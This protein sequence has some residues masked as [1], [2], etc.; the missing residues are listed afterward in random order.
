M[1]KAL[2]DY[3]RGNTLMHAAFLV[4]Y[5][6]ITYAYMSTLWMG[7]RV[8]DTISQLPYAPESWGTPAILIGLVIFIGTYRNSERLVSI[9]CFFGAVWCLIFAAAFLVDFIQDDTTPIALTG[10]LIYAH[11]AAVLLHR[12]VLGRRLLDESR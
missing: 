8:H 6:I 2:V 9:G 7:T 1:L 11:T 5:G 12:F 4:I 3:A 10:C